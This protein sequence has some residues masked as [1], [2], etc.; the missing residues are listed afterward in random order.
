VIGG[1]YKRD[2]R[3]PHEGGDNKTEPRLTIQ[4]FL[5]GFLFLYDINLFCGE[6][7]RFFLCQFQF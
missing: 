2:N 6:L 3:P 7:F 1:K 5:F 4:G